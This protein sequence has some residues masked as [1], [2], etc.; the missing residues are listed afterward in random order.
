MYTWKEIIDIAVQ[1]EHN[2]ERIYR[3]AAEH[4]NIPRLSEALSQLADDEAAHTKWFSRLTPPGSTPQGYSNLEKIA[5][6]FL[7]ESVVDKTLSLQEADFTVIKTL[8][9]LIETS[10]EFEQDTVVFYDTIRRL[11]S[12]D[13]TV[14]LLD[15]VI[16]EEENHI[17]VLNEWMETALES[18]QK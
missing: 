5:R 13:E 2:G 14:A 17:N 6:A 1:I 3:R 11:V 4:V 15:T 9:N 10:I 12:E 18:A 16:A 8:E 7:R